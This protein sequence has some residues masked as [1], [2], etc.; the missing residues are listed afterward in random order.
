MGLFILI[1]RKGNKRWLG[2]IPTR[3]G[4]RIS[5]LKKKISLFRKGFITKIINTTQLNRLMKR[6]KLKKIV[7][8]KVKRSMKKRVSKP[9]LKHA[10]TRFYTRRAI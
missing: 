4:T 10:H 7:N 8:T 3:K 1:K 2:A 6:L 5:Q 9:L